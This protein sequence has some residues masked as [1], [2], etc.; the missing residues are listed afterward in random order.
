MKKR[1]ARSNADR[2][3][4]N[5]R[6]SLLKSRGR[7]ATFVVLMA[8]LAL[9]SWTA[10]T[11]VKS[12]GLKPGDPQKTQ[13]RQTQK[14]QQSHKN[15][16]RLTTDKENYEAGDSITVK[17]R[18]WSPGETVNVFLTPGPGATGQT[19]KAT[20]NQDGSFSA[21]LEMPVARNAAGQKLIIQRPAGAAYKLTATGQTSGAVA[22][23]QVQDGEEGDTEDPDLPW[24]Q[25]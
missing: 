9:V 24:W 21:K 14:K 10:S 15:K 11:S 23:A 8:V 19:V 20:A 3:T 2:T 13:S 5:A 6:R 17:G 4:T 12:S 1:D 16:P 22:Q 18:N 7:L 25:Q